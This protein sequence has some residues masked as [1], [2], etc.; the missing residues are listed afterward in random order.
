VLNR[1]V[2]QVV[3]L[4]VCGGFHFD[5]TPSAVSTTLQDIDPNEHATVLESRLE[6]GGNLGIC[7]QLAGDSNR[8]FRVSSPDLHSTRKKLTRQSADLAALLHNSDRCGVRHA[9]QFW[10]VHLKVEALK[11]LRSG[12]KFGFRNLH[13]L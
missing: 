11:A 2:I 5:K 12:Y 7:D 10:L 6:D 13:A 4:E 8:L 1:H 3:V 9:S